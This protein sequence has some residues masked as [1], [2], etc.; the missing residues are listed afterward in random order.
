MVCYG[1]V[2]GWVFRTGFDLTRTDI[3]KGG[4]GAMEFAGVFLSLYSHFS[5]IP[6]PC[7]E[8]N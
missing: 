6:F 2:S 4:T 5:D 8:V 1:I 7:R 3:T